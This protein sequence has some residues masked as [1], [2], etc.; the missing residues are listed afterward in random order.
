MQGLLATS[1]SMW[2]GEISPQQLC[3]DAD[4]VYVRLAMLPINTL[5]PA[6]WVEHPAVIPCIR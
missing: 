5:T 6:S 1:G 2:G 4:G 3:V